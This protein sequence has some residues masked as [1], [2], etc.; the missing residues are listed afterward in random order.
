MSRLWSISKMCGPIFEDFVRSVLTLYV[1]SS[2]GRLNGINSIA[3]SVLVA[4]YDIKATTCAADTW[5]SE[6]VR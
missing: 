3:D 6:S 2:F 1:Q 5:K 4:Q